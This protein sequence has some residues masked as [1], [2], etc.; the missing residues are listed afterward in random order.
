MRE[1]KIMSFWI[2]QGNPQRFT[3]DKARYP[4]LHEINSYVKNGNIMSGV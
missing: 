1:E 2:F 3:I 4:D